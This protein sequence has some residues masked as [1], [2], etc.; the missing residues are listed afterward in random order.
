MQWSKKRNMYIN[1]TSVLWWCVIIFITM[2]TSSNK[3]QSAHMFKKIENVPDTL[4]IFLAGKAPVHTS[5]IH[6]DWLDYCAHT[7]SH[8]ECEQW[9]KWLYRKHKKIAVMVTWS[10]VTYFH[11]N[12][13]KHC[14]HTSNTYCDFWQIKPVHSTNFHLEGSLEDFM[15]HL[16][17]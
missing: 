5:Q 4:H 9:W 3:H 17:L 16:A 8:T 1:P 7:H 15:K 12:T 10:R 11:W 13:V 6:M 2:A 14:R